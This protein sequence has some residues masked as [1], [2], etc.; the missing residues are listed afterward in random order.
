MESPI[1]NIEELLLIYPLPQS[2]STDK[3]DYAMCLVQSAFGNKYTKDDIIA[4]ADI[5]ISA[6]AVPAPAPPAPPT[7]PAPSKP[8]DKWIARQLCADQRTAY[9]LKARDEFITASISAACAGQ[10]GPI[11]R[12]NQLLEKATRGAYKPFTGGY[13]TTQG[14]IYEPV[15]NAIYCYRNNAVIHA[16][17]LI[18]CDIPTYEF[19]AAS[20]DGI[21]EKPGPDSKPIFYNI[22][23]KT[24]AGRMLDNKIKKE[25]YHQMQ[26]QMWCLGLTQTHFLEAKYMEHVNL[27]S[28][29]AELQSI[30]PHY[31]CD[32]FGAVI[33]LWQNGDYVYLYSPISQSFDT[34]T[35]WVN[36]NEGTR[37]GIYIRTFYW[38]LFDYSCKLVRR[39][40]TWLDTMGPLLRQFWDEVNKLRADPVMLKARILARS[41]EPDLESCHL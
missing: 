25:Y 14:N 22:E 35:Q 7:P 27:M 30:E 32:K 40:P 18:A 6:L 5:D 28:L 23:I 36:D 2:S 13:Y 17:S 9:W 38:S 24:L 4:A 39:E 21:A 15:T 1:L 41:G 31:V 10:M 29:A 11:A 26:H 8:I 3:L 20:T 37:N 34:L 16:L 19:L 12:E 33:E